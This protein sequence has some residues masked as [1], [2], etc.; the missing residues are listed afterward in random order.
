MNDIFISPLQNS[1]EYKDVINNIENN[2]GTLL[3]NG[4]VQSQKPNIVYSIFN[5]L[6]KQILYIAN[7]DLEAKKVYEDLCFYMKD[8]VDYLSSQDIYFYHLDA[9][10]R[11]D[12]ARKLKV[13]LRMISKENTVIVTSVEAVLSKYVPK[14]VLKKNIFTY[15]IGDTIDIENISK[16]LVNLGYERV[17]KIE[18]FGQFSIRGGIIDV[19]SLEY[20]TPI[21]IELF[22]DEIESIRTFD[23]FTQKS[24]KKIKKCTITPSREFIYPEN[25]EES[26][27]RLEKDISKIADDDV[28]KSIE[29][30]KTKTYFEGVEN[31]IDYMYTD[32]NK[33]IF[34]YLKE[35]A[36]V[37]IND[38][39]RLK[40][41]CENY[42]NEFKE[43]YKL[44]LER[45]LALKQQG[46]LLYHY[47]DLEY[48]AQGKKLILNMLLTKS[49]K[50]IS[51]KSIVNFESREIPSFNG[52]LDILAEELTRLKYNGHKVVLATNTYDRA[53]KLNKELLNLGIETVLSRK[54]D[55]EIYSSQVVIVVGNITS[56]FQYKSIKFDVITDKE[57][58]GSNKRAKTSK[59]KKFNKGQKIETF[60]D[61]NV[62]DYV[63]HENS[64][65]GRYVG[66]DQLSVNG[67]KKDYMRVVYQGGDNLYVPIDQMDKIQK[68]IG[69]DTEKVKLNKLGSSEWSKAKA[70]VKKEIEDMTKDL[71][72][73]YAKREKIKGY[74]F[75]KDTLW[76]SEFET[77]FPYQETDDQIKAIEE[78][79]K[80]ME[81]N[82]V[83]DRLICGD[84]G[85][86]KTEV[87]I[88]AIFKACM[89]QKQ[90]AVLV[91]TTILAQQH[92]NTFRSRFENYPIRVEVLS[93]F[94]T[95]K[96]QKQIIEDARKGLVDVIIGTH[97]IIS[98]DIDLPNLGLVV[99]DEEQ[100]FGVKHKESLKKIKSTV[101]VLT[102]SATPIPR[103]L[104]MS[105]SGIRDMSVIE[106]P[107][108]ERYPVITYVV[109]GKE[110]II[111]DE[112]ER[113]IARGG[114][115][116]FVYNR[117]ERIDE[118][119]SM[120]QRLVPDAKIAV[121]HGRMTGKELE[122]I[123]IGFLN[124]EY[125]VLVC[126]TIIET[127]MDISNANTMIV[128]DADKMGLAQLYQL[129]GRVGRSNRQGYAYFMY[130][131]DK[132][133]SEIAEKR[134]KAIRE[135][136]EFGSG[137]KIAMRDLEIRG[138]G[139]ILGPQQ[140]GHM[141][142]IGYDLYVKMLNEAIRKVKGEVVQEEIDVEVDLPVNAYIPDS[143]IDDEII[144]I[145][146]YKKIA[147]IENEGDMNDIKDE[148]ADR[149]SD[150]PKSV[151]A[152]ISIAYI[153]T[154]CKQ[155][156]IEKVRMLK[157]EVILLPLTR[158]RTKEKNGYK[159]ID[160]L[161]SI[162]EQMCINKK[163]N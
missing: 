134:L 143:Y 54:R 45:G 102:L 10:D 111:Q 74:R 29:N 117:V 145:E 163:N 66:I 72:E 19:F 61:L 92:Y 114:Q 67:V 49:I 21:R 27:T 87:A 62:G 88:R 94:K 78:T 63:V 122:N 139:N 159:I 79:K 1:K 98:K 47:S 39:S 151:N 12:E 89:D 99:I 26:L 162:L 18:G 131:K 101:D 142:V 32:E 123:I 148:L 35:D 42:I 91:P 161:Q 57:M 51:V 70:K 153:K 25:T 130:E 144:K 9:K 105:L 53:K 125:N 104:H 138:A 69:A 116:F 8:K 11:N 135:F 108:Q 76:Q 109:E 141:A 30:I 146:M 103:T 152:L 157:D 93:R 50:D 17:S 75:S 147:S 90:V 127:G 71:V 46:N 73:L 3:I 110:S 97:R 115:V 150:I 85:Y 58:I 154:L 31:Y 140:H 4:L 43:N 5:D 6:K 120:I 20:D 68:F 38:V 81:S 155:V 118:M 119:A 137:F 132:V 13:L 124:K 112:I 22:D 28:Y 41:R 126:T 65:V 24:I 60:L 80:D 64:G 52:K 7:T 2:K 121:A 84:V 36:V 95:P 96:E 59:S 33:S 106:E 34:T 129:R 133:L 16:K 113:E 37:F 86:G 82:K 149:F 56:G 40:E 23:V 83:M 55:V 44:N 158:Y 14:E 128:Y 107:P 15:K 136:T 100:R 77:L 48:L 156:G 160:E